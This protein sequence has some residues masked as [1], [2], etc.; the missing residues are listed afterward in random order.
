MNTLIINWIKELN[1][2]LNNLINDLLN[3]K[4]SIDNFIYKIEQIGFIEMVNYYKFLNY[5]ENLKVYKYTVFTN[6]S[7]YNYTI[8]INTENKKIILNQSNYLIP[9]F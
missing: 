5:T 8:I 2:Q 1:T 7:I 6:T 9:N 3:S 4:V